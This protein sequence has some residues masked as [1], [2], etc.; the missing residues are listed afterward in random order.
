M[1]KI[2]EK[3][4]GVGEG[5]PFKFP[6]PLPKS[7]RQKMKSVHESRIEKKLFASINIYKTKEKLRPKHFN[8]C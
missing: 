8:P 1:Y 4:Q 6:F 2:E 7:W 5:Q 3:S